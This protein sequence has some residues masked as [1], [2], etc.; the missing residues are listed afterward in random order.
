MLSNFDIVDQS[1]WALVT[2]DCVGC[3]WS[4]VFSMFYTTVLNA[5]ENGLAA[6][7]SSPDTWFSNSVVQYWIILWYTLWLFNIAM[8]NGPFIDG[9][10]IKN[11][12]FPWLC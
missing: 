12:D 7:A 5:R 1:F 9:L 11:G 2:L 10:P 3:D 6:C 8:E 4:R